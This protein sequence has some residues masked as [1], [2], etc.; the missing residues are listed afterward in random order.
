M[1]FDLADRTCYLIVS[2]SHSYGGHGPD[3]DYDLRGWCIPPKSDF[4]TFKDRF[5]QDSSK[6]RY[7]QSPFLSLL[8]HYIESSGYRVPPDDEVIDHC[9]YSIHKFFRLTADCNPNLIENLYVDEEDVLLCNQWGRRVR[10]NRE[11]FLSAKAKHTFTGYAVSQLKRINT[12][13]RWLMDPPEKKP[14]RAEYGL[15]DTSVIPADQR[16]A[17][18]KLIDSQVREWLLQDADILGSSELALFHGR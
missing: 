2:G 15:P 5:Q 18:E 10:E 14:D 9:I 8:R 4:L 6:H 11:L 3:S 16:M 7:D 12:H 17:A 13:R 1:N